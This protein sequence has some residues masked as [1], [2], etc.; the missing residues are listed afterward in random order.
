VNWAIGSAP[1]LQQHVMK[2]SLSLIPGGGLAA[3][4]TSSNDDGAHATAARIAHGVLMTVAF[5]LLMPVGAGLARHK[6]VFGDAQTGTVRSIWF[7]LHRGI[8]AFALL[9]AVAAFTLIWAY[10]GWGERA[11]TAAVYPAHRGLG[12]AT[13]ALSVGQ[14]LI[15]VIRPHLGAPT[16]SGW[17]RLHQA[18][19]WITM[20][21]GI[22][23]AIIGIMLISSLSGLP[24]AAWMVPAVV[25]PALILLTVI[26]LEFKKR[27]LTSTG[28][29]NPLTH[30]FGPTAL[31]TAAHGKSPGTSE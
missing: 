13:M 8:Q 2:G 21:L 31:P 19:G 3:P 4:E 25:V 10:F 7:Q 30:T 6:W 15:G 29:Y 20:L 18:C 27:K 11:S 22:A 24:M 14:V 28:A 5:M 9:L 23:M 12:I 1:V 26:G 17:R 16:R